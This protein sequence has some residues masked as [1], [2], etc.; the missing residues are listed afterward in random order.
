METEL[1]GNE[2]RI[3]AKDW[4]SFTTIEDSK[5]MM[6]FVMRK[7]IEIPEIERISISEYREIEYPEDQVK[8]LK[9]IA[10]V[11][12]IFV[13][14]KGVLNLDFFP[15]YNQITKELINLLLSDPILCYV[16]TSIYAF[17]NPDEA[18]TKEFLLPLKKALEDTQLVK[19]I[20]DKLDFIF[21][22]QKILS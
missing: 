9:E 14:E 13:K 12:N 19:E 18:Y 22:H 2:L 20:K 10:N 21:F 7:L 1:R 8:M 6:E 16:K 11:Y 17:K 3:I 4:V 5:E 15:K